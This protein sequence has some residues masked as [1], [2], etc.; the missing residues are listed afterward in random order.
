VIHFYDLF[1][2]AYAD[3]FTDFDKLSIIDSLDI[4]GEIIYLG[5][6][7]LFDVKLKWLIH[8][9]FLNKIKLLGTF[10]SFGK[11]P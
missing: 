7:A 6:F 8:Y 10:I 5:S 9:S 11:I 2:F 4:H 1:Y 3:S